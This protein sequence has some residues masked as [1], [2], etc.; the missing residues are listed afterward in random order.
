MDAKNGNLDRPECRTHLIAAVKSIHVQAVP[1][2]AAAQSQTQPAVVQPVPSAS[3]VV[4]NPGAGPTPRTLEN[5]A[6]VHHVTPAIVLNQGCQPS[7][8][9]PSNIPRVGANGGVKS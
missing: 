6:I 7:P 1:L 9:P 3:A 5:P 2:D 8:P 4:L